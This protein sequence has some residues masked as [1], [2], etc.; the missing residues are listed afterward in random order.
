MRSFIGLALVGLGVFAMAVAGFTRFYI[1]PQLVAAPPDYYKVTRL[2]AANATYFDPGSVTTRRGATLTATSTIRGDAAASKR[3][4]DDIVVWDATAVIQDVANNVDLSLYRQ[5]I[6]FDRRTGQLSRCCGVHVDNDRNVA[7]AGLGLFW[8]L[9]I[10]PKDYQYFDTSTK[11]PWTMK[12]S[13]TEN[14]EGVKTYKFVQ[15]IPATRVPSP[16]DSVP[17]SLLGRSGTAS[18][19]ADRYHQA[20]VTYWID[21]RNGIPVDQQQQ[22]HVTMRPRDGGPGEL[23]LLDMTMRLTPKD[24]AELVDYANGKATEILLV[25]TIAPVALLAVGAVLVVSGLL[26]GGA[27]Q[28]RHRRGASGS[29][30]QRTVPAAG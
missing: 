13:G 30:T 28:P 21:A 9:D 3:A 2:E 27:R 17:A 7:M 29:G 20:T 14:V 1:A 15:T 5:R 22:V 16:T 10:E 18:V 12:Y 6:A 11:R 19:P 23:L 8:P 26:L 25:E 4:P 24:K